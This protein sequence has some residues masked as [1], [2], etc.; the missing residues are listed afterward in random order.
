MFIKRTLLAAAATVGAAAGMT[1]LGTSAAEAATTE[2]GPGCIS[3]FAKQFGTYA[4]PR[5]VEA[6]LDGKAEVGQPVVLKPANRMDPAQDLKPRGGPMVS[7]FHAA[8]MVSDAVNQRYGDLRA[9]Q[10]EFSP[11]GVPS[12]LCVGIA[13]APS[14]GKGLTLQSCSTPGTTVFIV[15]T[16]Y[17]PPGEPGFFPLISG[18]TTKFKRPYTMDYPRGA[19]PADEPTPHII[20]RRLKF[21]CKQRRVTE[22]QLFGTYFGVLG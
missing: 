11:L 9:A 22:R 10:I 19:H 4:D 15:G 21:V 17:S 13:G 20:L 14:Q 5:F 8:G 7:D 1:D 12:G 18:A 6:V 2:C 16:P 3:V